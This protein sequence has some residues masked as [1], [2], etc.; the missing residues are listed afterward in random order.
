MEILEFTMSGE[1]FESI[2]KKDLTKLSDEEVDDFMQKYSKE[3]KKMP[4]K[5][6]YDYIKRG[7][8]LGIENY[9]SK[10]IFKM[11]KFKK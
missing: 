5:H 10:D 4:L 7:S 8:N 1:D 2:K 9:F 3:N 11:L 6:G